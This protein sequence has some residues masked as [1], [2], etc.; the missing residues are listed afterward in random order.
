LA[1][2]TDLILLYLANN[3]IIINLMARYF[4]LFDEEGTRCISTRHPQFHQWLGFSSPFLP[5]WSG[6]TTLHGQVMQGSQQHVS[7]KK[8]GQGRQVR[9]KLFII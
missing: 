4:W 6:P 9:Q 5:L 1:V 3:T 8:Q 7:I 2:V